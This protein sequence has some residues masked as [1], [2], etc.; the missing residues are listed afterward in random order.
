MNL[1]KVWVEVIVDFC[2]IRG[3]YAK[4]NRLCNKPWCIADCVERICVV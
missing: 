1:N 3:L 2:N 4:I